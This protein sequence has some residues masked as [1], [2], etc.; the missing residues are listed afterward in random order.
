MSGDMNGEL[1]LWNPIDGKLAGGGKPLKQ[2]RKTITSI[3]WEPLH[4]DYSCQRVATA[5]KDGEAE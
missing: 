4:L 2:H 3:A 1:R 5:S